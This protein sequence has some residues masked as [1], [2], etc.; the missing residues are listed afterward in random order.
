MIVIIK[1]EVMFSSKSVVSEN[2]FIVCLAVGYYAY[3]MT[4]NLLKT[5]LFCHITCNASLQRIMGY[6]I[7][8]DT[9]VPSLIDEDDKVKEIPL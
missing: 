4:A 1:V 6:S 5:S 9:S 3:I 8:K 2:M 7:W